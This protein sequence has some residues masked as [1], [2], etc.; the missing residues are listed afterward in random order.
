MLA[1]RRHRV[2]GATV[3]EPEVAGVAGDV[4]LAEPAQE[5][6][7]AMGGEA[8]EPR[9]PVAGVANG[10]DHVVARPPLLAHLE[11]DLGRVLEIGVDDDGGVAGRVVESGGQRRL[12]P[13]VA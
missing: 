1:H 10:V 5:P 12:M 6:V 2:D 11:R 7:E 9:L 3:D 13:E 8:L 4:D